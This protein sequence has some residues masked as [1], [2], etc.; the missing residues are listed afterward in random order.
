MKKRTSFFWTVAILC[1]SLLGLVS[2][3]GGEEPPI[4]N[5]GSGESVSLTR[6]SEAQGQT[7]VGETAGRVFH[8]TE[9]YFLMRDRHEP[10][11]VYR[12]DYSLSVSRFGK[13]PNLVV[14]Y[15]EIGEREPYPA[16]YPFADTYT[17]MISLKGE[18]VEKD[19]FVD[20]LPNDLESLGGMT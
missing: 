7:V 19:L 17:H 18:F 9:D 14:G 3:G 1:L 4:F 8:I 5:P 2:C 12:V 15:S 16:E 10:T 11:L 20:D 6:S 13:E